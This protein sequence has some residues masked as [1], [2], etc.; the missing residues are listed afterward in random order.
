MTEQ[1]RA[2]LNRWRI[3][4]LVPDGAT[5]DVL[6]DDIFKSNLQDS[7]WYMDSA[8]A[9]IEYKD[10]EITISSVGEMRINLDDSV[11]RHDQ[12]LREHGIKD[13]K[14]LHKIPAEAWVNNSWFEAYSEHYPDGAVFHGALEAI[15]S[16]LT[17]LDEW[18]AA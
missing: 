10:Q 13:D 14:D 11:I 7:A 12:D 3:N 4:Q 6:D 8:I 16:V 15:R 17:N 2:K 1:D 18:V 5:L 9:K